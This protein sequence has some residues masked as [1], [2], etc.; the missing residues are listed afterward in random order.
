MDTS[1]RNVLTRTAQA[2]AMAAGGA[3]IAESA[4]AQPR[5]EKRNPLAPPPMAS[6]SSPA[7]SMSTST[8]TMSMTI[9]R[10]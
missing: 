1:R 2:A 7:R 8:A 9:R 10:S 3:L 4:R 5:L 6:T